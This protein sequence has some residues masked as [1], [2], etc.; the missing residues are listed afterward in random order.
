VHRQGNKK[1]SVCLRP[2]PSFTVWCLG[3]VM[4][5]RQTLCRVPFAPFLS[6]TSPGQKTTQHDNLCR[7]KVSGEPAICVE[8][9]C[10]SNKQC[11]SGEGAGSHLG[12]I[13]W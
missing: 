9:S 2:N 7:G 13:Q 1:W 8:G 11:F 6:A 5:I 4:N 3:A 10:G 12:E